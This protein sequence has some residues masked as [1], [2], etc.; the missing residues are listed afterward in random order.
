MLSQSQ[1]QTR[2]M[3]W[4]R[5]FSLDAVRVPCKS[6]LCTMCFCKMRTS[7]DQMGTQ[8]NDLCI[9][10]KACNSAITSRFRYQLKQRIAAEVCQSTAPSCTQSANR[11]EQMF[12]PVSP[13]FRILHRRSSSSIDERSNPDELS[14]F[15]QPRLTFQV[16][17]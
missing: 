7:W 9:G 14:S 4:G 11:T 10:C 17:S 2:W 15:S 1:D 12:R 5:S 6:C 3:M 8:N 16:T 13:C